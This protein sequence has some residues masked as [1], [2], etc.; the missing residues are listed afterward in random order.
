MLGIVGLVATGTAVVMISFA[1]LLRPARPPGASDVSITFL[2]YTNTAGIS[3]GVFAIS[4]LTSFRLVYTRP[5]VQVKMNGS[6]PRAD[7]T[8]EASNLDAQEQVV[9]I[10]PKPEGGDSWRLMIGYG[11][12]PSPIV[13]AL[14]RLYRRSP[15]RPAFLQQRI[16][17]ASA[18]LIRSAQS[19]EVKE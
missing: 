15:I 12:R 5:K 14:A 17:E 3:S 4:N 7:L 11:R 19:N 1:V 18:V 2:G 9:I 16:N 8:G 13:G 6:W 10:L